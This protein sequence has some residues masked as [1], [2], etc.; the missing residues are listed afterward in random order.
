VRGLS[1]GA[2]YSALVTLAET[3]NVLDHQDGH[4]PVAQKCKRSIDEEQIPDAMCDAAIAEAQKE[5][6][7]VLLHSEHWHDFIM[8]SCCW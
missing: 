7:H 1:L 3:G 4:D 8:R 5:V 6:S 2:N